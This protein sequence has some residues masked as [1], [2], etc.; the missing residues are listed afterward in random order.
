MDMSDSNFGR[1]LKRY[2]VT[3]EEL[4]QITDVMGVIFEQS[5]VFSDGEQIK[6]E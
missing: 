6:N 4:K 1:K 5:F 2:M 3:L